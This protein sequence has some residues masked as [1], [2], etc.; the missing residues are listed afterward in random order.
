ME[1]SYKVI[2]DQPFYKKFLLLLAILGVL[3]GLFYHFLYLP[4]IHEVADL[5]ERL[6]KLNQEIA[7]KKIEARNID[8]FRREFESLIKNY[9]ISLE[10]LPN[11]E[12]IDI[13]L[14]D[15]AKFETREGLDSVLFKP[16]SE[17]KEGF[18]AIVPMQIKI[19]GTYHQIGKFFEDIAGLPRIVNV[20]A[21]K[22]SSPKDEGGAISL[23][24]DC[25]IETYR[26]IPSKERSKKKGNR[27][28]DGNKK[29]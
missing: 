5:K 6:W 10:Q 25:A 3:F 14:M 1:L 16:E 22:F 7:R 26:Y 17:I 8:Q 21:F 12:M 9:K 15:I 4:R 28:Y 20:K 29:K 27:K 13:I 11:K 2:E 19:R 23:M 18:Y 24:A